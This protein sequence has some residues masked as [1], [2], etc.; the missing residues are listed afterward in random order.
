MKETQELSLSGKEHL[1][2]YCS[3]NLLKIRDMKMKY[4][5]LQEKVI[6]MLILLT[7]IKQQKPNKAVIRQPGHPQHIQPLVWPWQPRLA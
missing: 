7:R 6:N 5:R 4:F 3:M 1:K 2:N